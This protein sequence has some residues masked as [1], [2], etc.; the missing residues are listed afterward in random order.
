M[1]RDVP[2]S[3]RRERAF[4][5][6]GAMHPSELPKPKLLTVSTSGR[7]REFACAGS[8][9][10]G[11]QGVLVGVAGGRRLFD[12]CSIVV[13]GPGLSMRADLDAAEARDC[14][15]AL[16]GGARFHGRGVTARHHHDRVLLSFGHPAVSVHLG[17]D[18]AAALAGLVA[19]RALNHA[20]IA[21]EIA[22]APHQAGSP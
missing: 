1:S 10:V 21:G 17:P 6:R 2:S 7:P 18:V 14:A 11:N 22:D 5:K 3:V 15:D 20:A 9:L 4:Q 12:A 16:A 8:G 19:S 13:R